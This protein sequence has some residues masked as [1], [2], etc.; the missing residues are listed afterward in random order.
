VLAVPRLCKFYLGICLTTEKKQGKTSVREV[1]KCPDIPVAVLRFINF[2]SVVPVSLESK[3][4]KTFFV[5]IRFSIYHRLAAL[6]NSR[7]TNLRINVVN[8]RGYRNWHSKTWSLISKCILYNPAL[9]LN[10]GIKSLRAT[11][12]DEIFT[13]ILLIELCISLIYAWKPNKCNNY[14]FS[15]LIMSGSSYMFRRYIAILICLIAHPQYSI[16]CSSIEHLLEGTRNASR[17]WQ[18]NAETCRSY[19]T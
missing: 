13:G 17:G 14:S 11:M 9:Y 3:N 10:A 15:L 12:S 7:A 1:E 6:Y 2:H 19:H 5:Y 4:A 8:M 18:C 16:D